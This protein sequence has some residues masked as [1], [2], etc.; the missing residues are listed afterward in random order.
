MK[1]KSEFALLDVKSGKKKLARHFEKGGERI[2]VTI[3]GFITHQWGVDDG[4]SIEFEVAVESV[5][6]QP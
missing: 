4:I 6:V 2:P 5:E 1:L 3:H